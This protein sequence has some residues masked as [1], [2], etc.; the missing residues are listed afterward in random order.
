[1]LPFILAS[2]YSATPLGIGEVPGFQ[3]QCDRIRVFDNKTNTNWIL[4]INGV[5]KY[6][7]GKPPED[8]SRPIDKGSAI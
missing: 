7:N 5:Y 2:I 8:K 1:M 6:R 4:C 3:R